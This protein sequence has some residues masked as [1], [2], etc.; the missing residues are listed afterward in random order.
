MV[1]ILIAGLIA[2]L[3]GSISFAVIFTKR[4]AGFDVR[5]KGSKNA[6]STN[7]LRTAGKK[8][9]I[10][11]LVCDILKGVIS[12]LIAI[13]IHSFSL[14]FLGSCFFALILNQ[15]TKLI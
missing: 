15:K 12:I 3:I 8:A 9:A 7:V 14:I 1:S 2:Y 13:L 11:T 5:E 4:F 6:G 10:C